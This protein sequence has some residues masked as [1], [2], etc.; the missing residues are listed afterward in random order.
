MSGERKRD[1]AKEYREYHSKPEQVENRA[2]RNAARREYKK[3]NPNVNIEGRDIDHKK[4]IAHGGTNSES[5]LRVA[6]IK[7]N[8]GWRKGQS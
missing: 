7:V 6:S 1:Y 8:R 2:Q 5:N 4:R 3:D